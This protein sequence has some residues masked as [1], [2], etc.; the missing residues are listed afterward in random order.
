MKKDG[1]L[2]FRKYAFN[3][4]GIKL[5]KQIEWIEKHSKDIPLPIIVE[6]EEGYNYV[7]YDMKNLGNGIGMFKYIHTMPLKNSWDIL[8]NALEDIK[9][10]HRKNLRKSNEE[11]IKK[12][13]NSKVTNNLKIIKFFSQAPV[14]SSL[15]TLVLTGLNYIFIISITQSKN[16]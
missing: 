1:K 2:F 5:K 13:I 9:K 6:K 15:T 11:D 4:D 10:I 12:Y 14:I 8:E 16:K 3:D 7:T